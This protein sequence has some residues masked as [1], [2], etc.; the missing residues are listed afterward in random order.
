MKAKSTPSAPG[1]E[2]QGLRRPGVTLAAALACAA[3][4]GAIGLDVKHHLEPTSLEVA[5]TTSAEGEALQRQ[6]FGDSSPFVVLLRGPA[7]AIDRQ[8]PD[9]VRALRRDPSATAISSWDR[10]GVGGLRPGPRRALILVDFRVSLNEAV[11]HTVPALEQTM[12]EH[13]HPPVVGVQSGF[14]SVSRALEEESLSA[15][16]RAELLALPLLVI[17]LLIIFRSVTAAAIPLAFGVITVLAGRG[18]LVLL[19]TFMRIDALSLVV[20]TMMGLA[21]GVDYSL[22]IVSRFREELRAGCSPREAARRTRASAGR[23]TAFAGATLFTAILASAFVQP[24]GLLVSFATALVVVTAIS[25]VIAT[26]A[27]P[28]LLA[29]LG[30]RIDAGRIGARRE[31]GGSGMASAAQAALRRPAFAL[32]LIAAP[33]V[34]LASPALALNIGAPG[35]DELPTGSPARQNAEAIDEVVGPGWEA[36]FVLTA[37][38]RQGPITTPRRL[39]LLARWQRRIAARSDV[40]AVIGPAPI[41]GRTRPL[42]RMGERLVSQGAGEIGRLGPGLRRASVGVGQLRAGVARAAAGSALLG[43]GS[44]RA[45]TGAALLAGALDRAASG[46]ER[47]AGALDRLAAAS[48][49]LGAG[50]RRAGVAGLTLS[51][52]VRALLPRISSSLARARELAATLAADADADPSSRPQADRAASVARGLASSREELRRLGG[53][54]D[55]LNDGLDRLAS[56]GQRIEAGAERLAAAADGLDGKLGK[57]EAGAQRLAGGLEA[58]EG[59]AGSLKR[60]LAE[61]FHRSHPLQ[62]GLARAAARVSTSAA[63]LRRGARALHRTSPNLFSSGYFALSALDGAPPLRRALSGGVINVRRG[64]QAARLHVIPTSP[65]NTAGSRATGS[66][67]LADAER[68]GEEGRLETGV[69]GGAA[70]LNDYGAATKERLPLVVASVIVVTLLMLIAILR[71]PLLAFLTLGL[72]L[73]AVAAAMGVVSLICLVPAG[74]PL[75]GHPY[76]D[77]VGA[78]AIFG[79]TFGLSIDYAVFLIARM[80]ERWEA[81]GDNASAVAYGLEKTAGVITGAAAIMAVVF[82]SFAATPIATVSQ[83]GVGLFVAILLDATVVRIVLLPALM[84][85]LGERVWHVPAVLDRLLPDLNVHGAEPEAARLPA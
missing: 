50:Q 83:M 71:A 25:V 38:T 40:R 15:T 73:F 70:T 8:G 2:R 58:L 1:R 31:A 59:G 30:E 13:V 77:T 75:G 34:L 65:F 66:Q 61:G 51:L 4:L 29:L 84:L 33:L 16:K 36:P 72:N 78:A 82:L 52:G 53:V 56:G 11:R 48:Q 18:V 57:L 47:A 5:G 64:G 22:L 37:A 49:R 44:G 85:L 27:L 39:A 7:A 20:C 45:E 21:L 26:A 55:S 24:G 19:S 6:H 3:L 67:L 63:P 74:Y 80:R 28:A 35:V 60:G 76:I 10:G 79:V 42:R 68:L 41:A 14:A 43:E 62:A 46:G 12:R 69:S 17:V 9:L 54:A 32:V 23:T 81:S